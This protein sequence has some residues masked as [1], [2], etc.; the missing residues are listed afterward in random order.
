MEDVWFPLQFYLKKVWCWIIFYWH[1]F[2]FEIK[3][4]N[5]Y[6]KF[7]KWKDLSIFFDETKKKVIGKMRDEFG[8]VS[9]TE[10]VGLKSKMYSRKKIDGKE[11]NAAKRSKYCN[12]V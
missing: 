7:F 4:E 12:W 11:S 2:T 6:E 9:V 8:G 10:L 5:A 3:S 1:S